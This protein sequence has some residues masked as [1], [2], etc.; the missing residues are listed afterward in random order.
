MQWL[1]PVAKH[2]PGAQ[3]SRAVVRRP[4][5]RRLLG[6]GHRPRARGLPVAKLGP[7]PRRLLG[8]GH[9]LRA[10]GLRELRRVVSEAETPSWALGHRLSSCGA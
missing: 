3:A 4:W 10:R 5:A 2:G 6:A 1:L 9:G 8:A 7:Q